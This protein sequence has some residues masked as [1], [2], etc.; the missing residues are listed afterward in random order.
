MFCGCVCVSF[1]FI[2]FIYTSTGIIT[3]AFFL[4]KKAYNNIIIIWLIISPANAFGE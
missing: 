3:I 1:F 2:T 4:T